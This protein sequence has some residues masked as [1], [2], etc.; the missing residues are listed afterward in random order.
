[1]A[2]VR[3]VH[4]HNAEMMKKNICIAMAAFLGSFGC[5]GEGQ[6]CVADD[7]CIDNDDMIDASVVDA[8]GADAGETDYTGSCNV[9][10]PPEG[11][12]NNLVC[13]AGEYCST[14]LEER[15]WGTCLPVPEN[16]DGVPKEPVCDDYYNVWP[17]ACEAHRAQRCV[18]GAAIVGDGEPYCP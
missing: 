3:P 14:C 2:L 18:R 9:N 11:V 6:W 10:D 13:G 15:S 4:K 12:P 7:D 17:N 8:A 5:K 16:C 1:M